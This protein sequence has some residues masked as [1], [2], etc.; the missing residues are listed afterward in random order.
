MTDNSLYERA[1]GS[2]NAEKH[3]IGDES[4]Q[5]QLQF[6]SGDMD[7]PILTWSTL[8]FIRA[9]G[10]GAFG[11]VHLASLHQHE[12][13]TDTEPILLAVRIQF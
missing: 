1:D 2:T 10:E 5:I 3:V 11:Q 9:I 8:T 13:G 7:Y 6:S 12:T 4:D